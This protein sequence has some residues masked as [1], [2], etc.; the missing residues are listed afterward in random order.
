MKQVLDLALFEGCHRRER[1]FIDGLGTTLVLT[2][3]RRLCTQ[4]EPGR[5]FVV[6]LDG[7]AKV[8]LDG[9]EVAT[10]HDGD[11]VGE[12]SLLRG[13]RAA[14]TATVEAPEG[15]TVWALSVT[16]FNN[17][18]H[19]APTVANNLIYAGLKR[20]AANATS[21]SSIRCGDDRASTVAQRTPPQLTPN[22][23]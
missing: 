22:P 1:A 2:K 20:A 23:A 7:E 21:T 14:A 9:R 6:I 5:Q 18:I 12:I 11:Y 17:L 8:I 4:G 16:E 3:S 13:C 19:N 15:T 10:L